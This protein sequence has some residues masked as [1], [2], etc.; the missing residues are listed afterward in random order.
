MIIIVYFNEKVMA[1]NLFET[2]IIFYEHFYK[3]KKKSNKIISK[4]SDMNSTKRLDFKN[5]EYHK[6]FFSS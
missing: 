4:I 2:K 5:V 1:W 3:R 6:Q